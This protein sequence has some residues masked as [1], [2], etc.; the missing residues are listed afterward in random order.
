MS[1]EWCHDV[2]MIL[3]IVILKNINKYIYNKYVVYLCA[4]SIKFC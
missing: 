4:K 1:V 2:A 3:L